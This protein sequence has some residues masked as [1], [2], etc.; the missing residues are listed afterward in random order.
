MTTSASASRGRRRRK[1]ERLGRPEIND[2]LEL[3]GCSTD[4]TAGLLVRL[5]EEEQPL[6]AKS[7]RHYLPSP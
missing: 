5:A 4:V 3:V 6:C 2:S 7:S 1:T